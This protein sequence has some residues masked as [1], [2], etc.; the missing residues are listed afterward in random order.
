[1]MPGSDPPPGDATEAFDRALP[2]AGTERYDLRL[3]VAG[4]TPRSRTAIE[5]VRRI[6]AEYLRGR[7][8]FEVIDIYQEPGRLVED[9]ILAVP[10]L[11]R[12]GPLPSRRLVG[13]LSER[14]RVL[15]RLGLVPGA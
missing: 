11:I 7:C 6:C 5:N 1:M 9:Q 10:T 2:R 8:T 13:D 3:Y 12:R 4:H 14:S 15:A